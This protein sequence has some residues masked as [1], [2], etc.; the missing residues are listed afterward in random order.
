MSAEAEVGISVNPRLF[1]DMLLFRPAC[2]FFARGLWCVRVCVL[3]HRVQVATFAAAR[4]FEVHF[5]VT[6]CH[7][8]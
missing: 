8:V 4:S 7:S 3:V 1:P 5:C 6:C 2:A